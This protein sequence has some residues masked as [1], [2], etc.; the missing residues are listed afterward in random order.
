MHRALS[1]IDADPRWIRH[2]GPAIHLLRPMWDAAE[3]PRAAESLRGWA[4]ARLA[5]L[6]QFQLSEPVA[7]MKNNL[8]RAGRVIL[9]ALLLGSLAAATGCAVVK[10]YE[11][12]KLAHPTMS[13]A[14]IASMGESHLRAISEG[15]IGG[16]GGT[17][18]GCG[19]N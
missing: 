9:G 17:G 2:E 5:R 15:A 1:Y 19:C 18:S 8:A 7:I 16:S 13:A 12:A 3:T 4:G 11:R 6:V 10:P 14:G